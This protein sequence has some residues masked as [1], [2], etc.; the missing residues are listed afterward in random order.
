MPLR[1]LPK[2]VSIEDISFAPKQIELLAK[3]VGLVADTLNNYHMDRHRSGKHTTSN[4]FLHTSDLIAS[5]SMRKF[6]AREHVISLTEDRGD[7]RMRQV[8][9]GMRLIHRMGNTVQDHVTSDFMDGPHGGKVWGDWTCICGFTKKSF[10]FKPEARA[11]TCTKCKQPLT[12]YAEV[13]IT[14]HDYLISGH[15][16]L[17]IVWNNVLH[18][19]EIKSIDRKDVEFTTMDAPL[20]D[21][22]LQGSMYYWTLKD[23]RKR[24]QD[25]LAKN[26]GA[27]EPSI[28]FEIDPYINYLYAD[29]SNNLF[30]REYYK[31]FTKRAS[32]FS[33]IEPMLANAKLVKDS[34][35]DKVLPP[36]LSVCTGVQSSR[37]KNCNCAVSC[38]M[39]NRDAV[40]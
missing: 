32:P 11:Y 13:G 6:C 34:L 18:I 21:H 23:M 4:Y 3:P 16:D 25:A 31:E 8:S 10:S 12:K 2:P 19:Y 15:P 36:R 38:F 5:N 28:P 35:V 30:R 9:P 33:R 29:R 39:R 26:P 14:W 37:A 7:S 22:T 20:G 1:A 40:A 27:F 17:M 24:E